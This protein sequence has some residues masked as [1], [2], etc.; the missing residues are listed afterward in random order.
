MALSESVADSP[1]DIELVEDEVTQ[2]NSP[3]ASLNTAA[4]FLA[5]CQSPQVTTALSKLH[6]CHDL[7]SGCI[8]LSLPMTAQFCGIAMTTELQTAASAQARWNT[9]SQLDWTV[10]AMFAL[11]QRAKLCEQELDSITLL[12]ILWILGN[13]LQ[14]LAFAGDVHFPAVACAVAMQATLFT[15]CRLDCGW[16]FYC[17]WICSLLL[18]PV[19]GC[20][21][22]T[23][24]RLLLLLLL[25]QKA[26]YDESNCN[27]SACCQDVPNADLFILACTP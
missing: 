17:G 4:A 27:N 1:D 5:V 14:T 22:L 24:Q 18:S 26:V 10:A 11:Y 9:A 6:S 8:M 15:S 16:H 12:S 23:L 19:P 3:F 7:P 2:P 13:M 25:L 21:N 20:K